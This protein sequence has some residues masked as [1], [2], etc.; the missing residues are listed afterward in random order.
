MP[1]KILTDTSIKVNTDYAS[2]M[3]DYDVRPEFRQHRNHVVWRY[4]HRRWQYAVG[5]LMAFI[6]YAWQILFSL[7][8]GLHDV[9][10]GSACFGFCCSELMKCW[11]MK[12]DIKDT[13]V[14]S[15]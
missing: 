10:D 2:L 14:H 6:Q 5:D 8:D 4:S 13:A 1:I 7:N 15:A 12:P 9:Y 11:N 3:P